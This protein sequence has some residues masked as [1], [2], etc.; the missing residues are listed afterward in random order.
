MQKQ[1]KNKGQPKQWGEVVLGDF[2]MSFPKPRI[3]RLLGA[4]RN[5][6]EGNSVYPTVQLDMPIA[7]VKYSL[8]AGAMALSVGLDFNLI[9]NWSTRWGAVFREYA[10]VGAKIEARMNNVV[11]PAG[12]IQLFLDEQAAAVPIAADANDRPRLDVLVTQQTVPG[13]YLL[14]WTPRDI[15]DLDFVAVGTLFTPVYLKA[16]ATVANNYTTAT[17]TGDL[18]VTGSLALTFRGYL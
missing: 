4:A 3:P 6:S 7:T 14:S 11:N 13:A 2:R 9:S 18:I 17:T 15:L 16:F 8:V 1:K 10:I 12:V 5:L